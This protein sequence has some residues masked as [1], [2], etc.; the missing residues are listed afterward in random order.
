MIR[1]M[2][3]FLVFGSQPALSLAEAKAIYP[4]ADFQLFGSAAVSRT[5]I[6]PVAAV[7]RLG[8]TVKAGRILLELSAKQNIFDGLVELIQ[9][10]PRGRKILFSITVFGHHPEIDRKFPIEFKRKL[11]EAGLSARWFADENKQ[12]SPAAVKKA[13]LLDEGYDIC[14]FAS[15]KGCAI[16]FSETVQDPD[17][18]TMRDM[19]RPFRDAQ[20]G[21]LPPKLARLLV[22]LAGA[23][24]NRHLLDP[25]CG[26]GTIPMEASLMGYKQ[27]SG[28]DNDPQQV[29]DTQGNMRWLADRGLITHQAFADMRFV[30]SEAAFAHTRI[31]T[32]VDVIVTEG[33]LGTPLKGRE[34]MDMLE[35]E[36]E[37]IERTWTEALPTFARMQPAGGILVG[38]WPILTSANGEVEINVEEAAE[39]AGYTFVGPKDLVY[40]RPEQYVQRH[41]IVLR[42]NG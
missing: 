39:A 36:A 5:D 41:I 17:A 13:G 14:L 38:I 32:P 6:D 40:S 8:G 3:T 16:G 23:D 7:E 4:D 34:S 33:Y 27:I 11:Q 42:K 20:N 25:F 9:T 10:H 28:S 2:S 24:T 22:N 37:G 15:E 30:V 21:M 26:S 19:G 18:W 12:V 31:S 35:A 1:R 29:K